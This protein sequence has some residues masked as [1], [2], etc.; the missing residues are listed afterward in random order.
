[1][2]PPVCRPIA[3]T[4]LFSLWRTHKERCETGQA[5]D[6]RRWFTLRVMFS[7]QT[8]VDLLRS[9]GHA[10]AAPERG[11]RR[12]EGPAARQGP[13]GLQAAS[14]ERRTAQA[15]RGIGVHRSDGF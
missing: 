3:R 8:P 1:M 10:D 4:S 2:F 5:F 11:A 14:E 15:R 13:R 12:G 7:L 9:L 6:R